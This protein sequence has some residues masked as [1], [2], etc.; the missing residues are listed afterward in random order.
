M[1]NQKYHT[2]LKRFGAAIVDGIVFMPLLLVCGQFSKHSCPYFIQF[3]LITNTDK[4]LEN[5]S[6]VL[7]CLILVKQKL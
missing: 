1:D 4:Q 3:L 2:G 5:G 6:L 7:K